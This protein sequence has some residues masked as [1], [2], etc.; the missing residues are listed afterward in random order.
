[1]KRTAGIVLTVLVVAATALAIISDTRDEIQWLWTSYKNE[2]AD[3]ESYLETWPNGRHVDE[4]DQLFDECG[5]ADAQRVRTVQSFERYV[6]IHT[7]GKHV[8]ESKDSIESLHWQQVRSE[9]VAGGFQHYLRIYPDGKHASDARNNIESLDWEQ[10]VAINTVPGFERYVETHAEGKHA[11]EAR[12][13]IESLLWQ[14]ARDRGTFAALQGYLEKYPAGRFAQKAKSRQ[15]ALLKDDAPFLAAQEQYTERA[16][17][18]FLSDFPGHR[19]ER[20]VRAALKDLEGR[21]IVDLLNEGKIEIETSGSGIKR[22]NVRVRRLVLNPVTIRI[23]VGTFFVSRNASSQNMVTTGETKRTLRTDD[24][25]SLSVDAACA[26]RPRDIPDSED[27][28]TVRRSPH[29]AELAKLMSVLDRAGF[30]YAVRQAAVWIVTDN[31]D[32]GELGILV[33]RSFGQLYGGTREINE[34]EAARAMQ[35]CDEAGI[36]ITKKAIWSDCRRIIAGLKDGNLKKWL[37][38]KR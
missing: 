2:T 7:H 3:Y 33:S 4:A 10:A 24:W 25:V 16:Y 23:P 29:Q 1:M 26:N 36:D 12:S 6:Q 11:A 22:V 31:A 32:Y 30:D 19:R 21:D 17:R 37:E 15:T 18:A 8:V 9:N 34:F 35:I 28:F 38:R 5:W 27:N 13:N 14:R 20:D